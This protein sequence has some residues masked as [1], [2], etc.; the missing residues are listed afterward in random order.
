MKINCVV[1]DDEPIARE[2]LES[3]IGRLPQ[4]TLVRSCS[5]AVE[6]FEALYQYPV[7]V[8]FL[9]IQM[10]VIT[11]TQFL[12]S[13]RRPPLV[14]FTTAYPKYAAEGLE[15]NAVD[16]LLKP[17]TF[18]RFGEAVERIKERLTQKQ[19]DEQANLPKAD[20][21][22][23]KQDF[24]LVKVS[25]ADIRFI[26]AERDFSLVFLESKKLMASMHLK[27]FEQILPV[28]QFMRVHRSYMV[29]LDKIQ[30]IKGN[31]VEIGNTGIPIG[32]N[33][34]EALFRRLGI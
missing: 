23:I 25:F 13:L 30:S 28:S 34:K 20:Y 29:N 21:I 26:Q 19:G 5:N 9:D 14:V 4:L 16:Y 33:Y 31:V 8:I 15:L 12:R 32:A 22:F 10:P 6:T 1:T 24:R 11:G 7:D 17:I 3:Y 27:L 2:I 18:E